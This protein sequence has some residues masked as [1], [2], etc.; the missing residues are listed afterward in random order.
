MR[1][2][3]M[4]FVKG[5]PRMGLI[6]SLS[7]MA[8][9]NVTFDELQEAS[10]RLRSDQAAQR[11][12]HG[13][14]G[15]HGHHHGKVDGEQADAQTIRERRDGFAPKLSSSLDADGS[16]DI[17]LEEPGLDESTYNSM[18]SDSDGNT[19]LNEL[20]EALQLQRSVQATR[21]KMHGHHGHH[22]GRHGHHHGKVDGEQADAQ[23]IRERRN[24]FATKLFNGLDTDGSGGISLE[25]SGLDESTYNRIDSDLDGNITLDELK[26][27]L[28]RQRAEQAAQRKMHGRH[29]HH[30]GR[31]GHHHGKVDGEK[32]DAQTILASIMG[33]QGSLSG[34]GE[35]SDT[36]DLLTTDAE[37]ATGTDGLGD[38]F[39]AIVGSNDQPVTEATPVRSAAQEI[40]AALMNGNGS[41]L[42][43]RLFDTLDADGSGGL[44]AAET[45][46][47]QPLFESLDQDGDGF[48]T[49]AELMAALQRQAEN[50]DTTTEA[51]ADDGANEEAALG[52]SPDEE[53]ENAVGGATDEE[54]AVEEN[55]ADPIKTRRL[56]RGA[57]RH[58]FHAY[59]RH[60]HGR[61][62]GGHGHGHHGGHHGFNRSV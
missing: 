53:G 62:E 34:V 33:S 5:V 15:R 11:K 37:G 52:E 42:V 12:M 59:G 58:M 44:T 2:W 32:P 57:R 39:D 30:H 1:L 6:T 24:G 25:E 35:T 7:S 22:H 18:D 26:E 29:G 45:G 38:G 28:Q 16:G 54:S 43:Q 27:A 23:T 41:L 40:L 51:T 13:H 48:V 47:S 56:R 46:L 14:H 3:A 21:M 50:P 61:H 55:S 19:T 20:E 31:H 8:S 10:R 36:D 17:S 9:G 4:P 49:M 60:I